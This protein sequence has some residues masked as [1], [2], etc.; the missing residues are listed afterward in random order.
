MADCVPFAYANFHADFLKG[1]AIAIGCPKLDDLDAYVTKVTQIL[2]SSD[3][4]SLRVIHME[5]PCCYGLL[6]IAQEALSKSGKDIPFES[7]IVGIKGEIL[8]EVG[9]K[10]AG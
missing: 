8:K 1:K 3:I 4:K 6:H 10:G 7:V 2:E 9:S 5:V